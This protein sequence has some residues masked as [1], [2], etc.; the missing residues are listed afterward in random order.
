MGKKRKRSKFDNLCNKGEEVAYNV[1]PFI[2]KR[3]HFYTLINELLSDFVLASKNKDYKSK[4]RIRW[5]IY[6]AILKEIDKEVERLEKLYQIGA[7]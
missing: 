4:D 1:D 3:N 2:K 7:L 6:S 5:G